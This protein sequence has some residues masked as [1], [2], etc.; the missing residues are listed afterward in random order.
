MKYCIN[1]GKEIEEQ[2]KYCHY[3]GSSQMNDNDKSNTVLDSIIKIL[4]ILF[5]IVKVVSGIILTFCFIILCNPYTIVFWLI[6]V[7][8]G[9]LLLLSL[10][11]N[12]P[13]AIY[14]FKKIKEQKS[15]NLPFS[16]CYLIFCNL[17]VGILLIIRKTV[18]NK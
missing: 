15:L 3:C 16:I 8:A 2:D 5:L 18:L 4:L 12:I 14:A 7:S 11:W 9:C 1:C 17:I 10:L 6:L 13:M